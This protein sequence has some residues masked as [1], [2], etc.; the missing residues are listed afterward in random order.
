MTK[1]QKIKYLAIS[2]L[3]AIAIF[4]GAIGYFIHQSNNQSQSKNIEK[5]IASENQLQNEGNSSSLDSDDKDTKKMQRQLDALD[6]KIYQQ[7][8]E[9]DYLNHKIDQLER[10]QLLGIYSTSTQSLTNSVPKSKELN[11]SKKKPTKSQKDSLNESLATE[12]KP[13]EVITNKTTKTPTQINDTSDATLALIR[14]GHWNVLNLSDKTAPRNLA[15]YSAIGNIIKNQKMNLIGLTE[16]QKNGGVQRILGILN[17]NLDT[18]DWEAIVSEK[19]TTKTGSVGQSERVAILY[20]KSLLEPIPFDNYATAGLFYENNQWQNPFIPGQEIDYIRPPFG[21]KFKIIANGED[22]TVVYSHSD[23]PGPHRKGRAYDIDATEHGFPGQG[24]QEVN[25]ALHLK[26]VMEWFD[27]IDGDNEE[28]FYM[29]DTNIKLGNEAKAFAPLISS[30]YTSLFPESEANK[31][32][33]SGHEKAYASPYDK[34]FYKGQLPT[35]N[36][37]KGDIFE[38]F[39]DPNLVDSGQIT[40][41]REHISDHTFTFVDLI[42]QK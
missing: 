42:S 18:P 31:T 29:G 17:Q 27:Q 41:I 37:Q 20:Q 19:S 12:T 32:T 40:K 28:L 9:L 16:V 7:R 24:L 14:I 15:K 39:K 33:L 23:A 8:K 34:M 21:V 13:K 35:Q 6:L 30:G 36:A 1:K 11:L 22:F 2:G 26:E 25:E 3:G 5:E 38:L 4:S 10:N